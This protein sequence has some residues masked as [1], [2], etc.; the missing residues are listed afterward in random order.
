[1]DPSGSLGGVFQDYRALHE[2]GLG[3]SGWDRRGGQPLTGAPDCSRHTG[4]AGMP[5]RG[6]SHGG[7]RPRI[8]PRLGDPAPVRGQ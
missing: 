5:G 2:P 6:V 8:L 3:G 1:M 4:L 7:R